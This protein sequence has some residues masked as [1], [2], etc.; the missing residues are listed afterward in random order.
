M[1]VKD[2]I[3]DARSIY[4]KC[5]DA[6]LFDFIEKAIEVLKN[7]GQWDPQVGYADICAS[8]QNGCYTLPVEI[9]TPL[10]V[11][12]NGVPSMARDQWY[13]FH[14]NGLGS[15]G[16]NYGGGGGGCSWFWDDR[17]DVPTIR[18]IQKPAQI[19]AIPQ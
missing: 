9:E 10:A 12:V 1:L 4:G 2:I 16:D 8:N 14:V 5:D 3:G 6:A 15:C 11:S 7:K 18:D 17:G 19:M 13:E